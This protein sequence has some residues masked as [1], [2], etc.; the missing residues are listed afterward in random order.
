M[1]EWKR[2]A[3]RLRHIANQDATP[4]GGF[5]GQWREPFQEFHQLRMPPIA[6]AR[7]PHHLPIRS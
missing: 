5:G 4:A 1:S 2:T 3:A 7:H 6:I